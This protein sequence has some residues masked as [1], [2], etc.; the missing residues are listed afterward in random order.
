MKQWDLQFTPSAIVDTED[1]SLQS[2]YVKAASQSVFFDQQA[3]K[4]HLEEGYDK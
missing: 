4:N 1:L 3:R 2:K